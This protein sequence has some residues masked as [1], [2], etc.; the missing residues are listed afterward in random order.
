MCV[1]DDNKI[2][3]LLKVF[4]RKN[5]FS[6]TT[7]ESV[8]EAKKI[9]NRWRNQ[10]ND[11]TPGE[12]DPSIIEALSDDLNSVAAISRLHKLSRDGDFSKLAIK[13]RI[14]GELANNYG[15]LIQRIRLSQTK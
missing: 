5:N 12:V 3:E 2:R 10:T 7:A 15:N 8:D 6:V 14:N 9:L 4:L 13:N 11:I 1:D